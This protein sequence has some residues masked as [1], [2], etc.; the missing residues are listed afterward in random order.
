[1]RTLLICHHDA[2]MDRDGLTRWLASFSTLSGVVVISEPGGRWRKRVVRE[3]RRVGVLRFLD[4]LAFRIYYHFT[5]AARDK[6]WAA[7]ELTRLRARFPNSPGSPEL[8]VASPNS[9]ET[10]AFIKD[11]QPD[12]IVARCKTLLRPGVFSLARLGT[13][14]MHP[15][16]CPEYRNAHG[17]FWAMARGDNENVGM[18]LL[19]VDQGVDTGPVYGY[20]RVGVDLAES[21]VV[22][23]HRIVTENLDAIRDKL[24]DIDA[25]LASPIVTAGRSS[26]TWGQPWLTALFNR[27]RGVPGRTLRPRNPA[28]TMRP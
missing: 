21:H 2:E 26:A 9:T 6:R 17:C 12:L 23:Q 11:C 27:N 19:R 20:F 13:F 25:G 5:S 16:I 14:V 4:V 22:T 1:M 10:E 7:A 15:G 24:R 8:H 18:T 28:T 3:V